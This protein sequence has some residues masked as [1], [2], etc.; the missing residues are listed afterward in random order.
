M[1][2]ATVNGTE[3]YYE[4]HGRGTPLLC[5]MGFATDSIGWTMQTPA[6]AEHH[7]T[8]V[9]D[10]RGVGRSAKPAGP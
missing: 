5:I 6:F 9:F 8:I 4:E 3:L 2:T 10:N 1:P 7:R